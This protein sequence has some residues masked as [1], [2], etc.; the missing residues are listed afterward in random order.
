MRRSSIVPMVLAVAACCLATPDAATAVKGVKY[1]HFDPAE[2]YCHPA[3]WP[4][5]PDQ[6]IGKSGRLYVH[7][8]EVNGQWVF[9]SMGVP[10]IPNGHLWVAANYGGKCKAGYRLSGAGI[11]M[12]IWEGEGRPHEIPATPWTFGI[13]VNPNNKTYPDRVVDVNIPIQEAFGSFW[14]QNGAGYIPTVLGFPS[15]EDVWDYGES[16]IAERVAQGMTEDQARAE[17]FSFNTHIALHGVVWCE[18]VS[19]EREFFMARAEWIP[20]EIVFVGV[21]QTAGL[22][23]GDPEPEPLGAADSITNGVEITQAFLNVQQD[24]LDSCRLRLTG[25]FVA[26]EPTD[27]T[28]RFIDELGAPSQLFTTTIDQTQFD[29]VDHFYDLPKLAPP[30]QGIDGLTMP[31]REDGIGG[32]QPL[33]TDKHQGYFQ[34]EILEPH[35]FSSKVAGYN[36]EPCYTD[37]VFDGGFA[38]P[39]PLPPGGHP[40]SSQ[41]W[42]SR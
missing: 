37:P 18:G 19:F 7:Q 9:S 27:V 2:S 8:H 41:S 34:I 35:A 33:P 13:P 6:G 10:G 40:P 38:G 5:A 4:C 36:V 29:V 11:K 23:L 15:Y 20:L 21:G 30:P 32:F 24:H 28:Y 1:I 14:A 22:E 25:I 3:D 12:G 16:K 31:D 26:T 39:L 17:S 42:T